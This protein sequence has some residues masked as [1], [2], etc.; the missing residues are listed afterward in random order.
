MQKKILILLTYF[1]RPKL[2]VNAINSIIEANKLHQNWQLVVGDDNSKIPAEPIVKDILKN[3]NLIN[4][5]IYIRSK[6]TID[7]KIKEGITIGKYANSTLR[8]SDADYAIILC[9][10]DE[11]HPVY[12]YNLNDFFNNHNDILYC[13]S[14][15]ILYNP[16]L[17]RSCDAELVHNKYNVY[18]EPINCAGKVDASQVAWRL[19][20]NKVHNAWFAETTGIDIKRPWMINTD[21]YFFEQLHD[22]CGFGHYTG[23]FSQYKGIHDYQLLW[24]KDSGIKGLVKYNDKIEKLGGIKF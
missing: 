4:P 17:Q 6:A 16:L 1:N 14:D 20:C 11:L 5:V 13:Y 7:Q 12:L 9:D 3:I 24:Y 21:Q 18:K 10:D 15:L 23:F 22:K 8:E 2:V 19:S